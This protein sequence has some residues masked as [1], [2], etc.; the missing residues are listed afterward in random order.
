M[1]GNCFTTIFDA[2]LK[3]LMDE[4][5]RVV[6]IV[7]MISC[8]ELA[9][10]PNKQPFYINTIL[11][12]EADIFSHLVRRLS[13]TNMTSHA[14]FSSSIILAWSLRHVNQRRKLDT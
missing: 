5:T 13:A 3:P 9:A 12:K 4:I 6:E 10:F 1:Q 11:R 14:N 8:E 7:T 2:V